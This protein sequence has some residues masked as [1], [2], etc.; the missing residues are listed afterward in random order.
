MI[1]RYIVSAI[2]G[3]A[4]GCPMVQA[5]PVSPPPGQPYLLKVL[6]E[7]LS[8]VQMLPPQ[9][10]GSTGPI[11]LPRDIADRLGRCMA[12]PASLPA[13]G[14]TATIKISFRSNGAL[15]GP[16]VLKHVN[17]PPGSALRSQVMRGLRDAVIGCTPLPFTPALGSAIAGRP[18]LIRFI[19]NPNP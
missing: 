13:G 11:N 2:A 19:P 18:V 6:T 7:D 15:L 1:R 12:V 17:V 16:P 10:D 8:F 3:L 5:A 14:L 9:G 4:L